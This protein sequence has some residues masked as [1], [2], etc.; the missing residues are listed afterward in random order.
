[1]LVVLLSNL[2]IEKG[3]CNGRQGVICGY[4]KYDLKTRDN[5]PERWTDK[6]R[7]LR[8]RM[9]GDPLR[10][11]PTG[12]RPVMRGGPYAP[13][14]EC[15]VLS[16]ASRKSEKFWPRVKFHNGMEWTI[17][18]E[19]TVEERGAKEPFTLLCRTQIPL[20]PAWALTIHKSQGMTL[21]RVIVNADKAFAEGQVYVALSRA[22]SLHG[23][24][25]EGS[26]ENLGVN[27]DVME[28]LNARFGREK[29]YGSIR[30]DEL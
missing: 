16:Y 12:W 3:L 18:A 6:P 8:P 22:R 5:I 29:I 17:Y 13:L 11:A 28:F 4:E 14:R 24:K 7:P 26:P 10:E 30:P 20:M 19:C 21:D 27:A 9:R 1:M 25:V 15:Q 23:L 2:N